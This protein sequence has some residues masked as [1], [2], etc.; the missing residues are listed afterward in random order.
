MVE[1]FS[2]LQQIRQMWYFKGAYVQEVI[3][4]DDTIR[5]SYAWIK[6]TM[7][8]EILL[9]NANVISTQIKMFCSNAPD[10]AVFHLG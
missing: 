10:R 7:M 3:S 5:Y 2:Y 8:F 6:K 9:W 4:E 1:L